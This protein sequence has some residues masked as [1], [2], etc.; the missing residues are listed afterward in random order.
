MICDPIAIQP[1]SGRA[2][3]IEALCAGFRYLEQATGVAEGDLLSIGLRKPRA[4]H[5]AH[6]IVIAHVERKVGAQHQPLGANHRY[7]RLDHVSPKHA[8]VEPQ[9]LQITGW[10]LCGE[11]VHLWTDLPRMIHAT[12]IE[13]IEAAAMGYHQVEL[14]MSIEH[15]TE[16]EMR[17]RDGFLDRLANAVDHE[18]ISQP[19]AMRKPERMHEQRH[20]QLR[21]LGIERIEDGIR[22]FEILD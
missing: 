1:Q 18:E 21:Q 9:S 12:G 22:Q 15:A 16:N 20:A 19:L 5:Q 17:D 14:G 3:T 6:R 10:S 7:Q 8:G 2:G 4:V 13:W 11:A